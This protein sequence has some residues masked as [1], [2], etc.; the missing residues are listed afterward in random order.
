MSFVPRQNPMQ[1][2][3]WRWLGYHVEWQR[4]HTAPWWWQGYWRASFETYGYR[5][6]LHARFWLGHLFFS[7]ILGDPTSRGFERG[8]SR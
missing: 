5:R 3:R 2:R 4:D 7:V 6:Y 8:V 1:I